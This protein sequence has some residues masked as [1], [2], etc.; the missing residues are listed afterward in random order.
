[1]MQSA[2]NTSPG[3]DLPPT[4]AVLRIATGYQASQ[5]LYVATRLG[6]PDLL[7]GAGKTADELAAATGSHAGALYRL[8]RA[9]VAFGVLDE[10]KRGEFGLTPLGDCLRT[11][12]PSSMR[13][14]VLMFGHENFWQTTR[15]LADC[16]RTGRT[17]FSHLFGVETSFDYYARQPELAA[18]FNEGMTALSG[19]RSAAVVEALDASGADV[20]VDVAGGH[21]RLISEVLKANLS[22]RGILFDL[23]EV[24]D[25]ALPL[26][27]EAGVADRCERAGGDI[28]EA[29][30]PGGDIY[31]MSRIIHDWDDERARMILRNCRTAM[32]EKSKLVVVDIVLPEKIEPSLTIQSQMLLDLNMLARTGGRERTE[33][34]FGKLF[35][36][37]G[38]RLHR[39]IP[40]AGAVS[41]VEA[42]NAS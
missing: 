39:I 30:P 27:K 7:A 37:A 34:E 36:S 11:D 12:V 24:V 14:L 3:A 15:A 10:R 1:M 29:V 40:T 26:L 6:I 17:A 32:T 16:V 8:L 28:F 25:G 38:L 35:D 19:M 41:L 23:P 33:E 9:L 2:N 20:V 5:A 4:A 42:V 13:P 31:L 18:T 22:T 21:G